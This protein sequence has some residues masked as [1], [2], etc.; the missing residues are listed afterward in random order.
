MP[1]I[2]YLLTIILLLAIVGGA[3]YLATWDI[4]P[5]LADVEN[6]LP[7]SRFP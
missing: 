4:P 5:P 7:N 6:V 1:R 3:I 2:A